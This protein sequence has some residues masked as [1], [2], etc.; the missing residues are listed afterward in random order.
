ML[1]YLRKYYFKGKWVKYITCTH[2]YVEI[3]FTQTQQQKE[4]N[5]F[6]IT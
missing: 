2:I 5:N 1:Q 6:S 4:T 3:I